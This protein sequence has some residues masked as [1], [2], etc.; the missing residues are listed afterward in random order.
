MY[1]FNLLTIN[2]DLR[3]NN[4]VNIMK[5]NELCNMHISSRK[6]VKIPFFLKINGF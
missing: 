1:I 6:I 3:Y 4:I 2:D 5:Y